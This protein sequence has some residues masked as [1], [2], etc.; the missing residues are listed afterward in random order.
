[1]PHDTYI[2][3][4]NVMQ[5]LLKIKLIRS[6]LLIMDQH[7]ILYWNQLN[8]NKKIT[9]QNLYNNKPHLINYNIIQILKKKRQM[10]M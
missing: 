1:M 3:H 7:K 9:Y 4:Q 2:L 10:Y 5:T 8:L 6:I